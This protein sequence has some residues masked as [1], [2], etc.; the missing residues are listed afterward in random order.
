MEYA[1]GGLLWR[2]CGKRKLRAEGDWKTAEWAAVQV[3]QNANFQYVGSDLKRTRAAT[4]ENP[5]AIP[6]E[7]P[8]A[9]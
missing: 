3:W 4:R 8:A 5:V 1:G 6:I 7:N 2:S 9:G